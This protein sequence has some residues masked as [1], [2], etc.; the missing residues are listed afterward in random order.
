[1]ADEVAVQP[2]KLWPAQKPFFEWG[3]T[4]HMFMGGVGSGK[5]YIGIMKMLYLLDRYPGSRGVI[6]RQRFQQ[7]KKT[8]SATLWKLLPKSHVARRNDNE[9][10]LT[11]TN[12]SQLLLM[13]LDKADSLSNMKSLEVNFAFV[14]QAEDISAEAWDTLWERIGRWSGATVRGG[15]PK[16]WP[17]R[18]RLGDPIPPRYL[19]GNCYS[20]GYDHWLTSRFWEFGTD[21]SAYVE[22]GYKVFIGSTKDNL[23][24]SDEYIQSRLAMGD[25]YVRR[26]V[27]AVDWG[28]TEGRIFDLK[29][30]SIL[31]PTADLL[32]KIKYKMKVHR[33]LDHGEFSPSACLWYATDHDENVFYYRE[34]MADNLVVS[35]HRE[36]IYAMSKADSLGG[37]PFYSSNLADPAIFNKNRGRTVN[38]KPTWSVADEWAERRVVDPKTAIIWRP[39]LND[40]AMTINRVREY[41]RPDAR[42]RHPITGKLGAPRAYFIRRTADYPHGCHEVLTD[43]RAAR[44]VEVGVLANGSK[45]YGD[46]RDDKV[47]DHLLDG[48]RYSIGMR[49]ALARQQNIVEVEPGHINLEEYLKITDA[50]AAY[51]GVQARRE[52][53]G[54]YDYGR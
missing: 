40:E 35:E 54:K 14:D 8:T 2:V 10:T 50:E 45:L 31:D 46:E 51:R 4:P 12:G 9:G 29:Q 30:M 42:H 38:N 26:F 24:L 11:L 36:N 3:P 22:Q 6:V 33:V 17:Y 23:A 19:F 1:M 5:T 25:E 48:V 41:L 37:E 16:D 39:A 18:N 53:K 7:L 13:H 21:R 52:W 28:A 34:Y 49:P 15:W 43:L 32:A 47:R 20:P 44:R 27:D